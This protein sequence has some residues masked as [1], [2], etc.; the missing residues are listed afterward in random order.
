MDQQEFGLGISA[1]QLLFFKVRNL[2]LKKKINLSRSNIAE[3]IHKRFSRRR[4]KYA[5][6]SV[7]SP[8]K[9]HTRFESLVILYIFLINPQYSKHHY[10]KEA[11]FAALNHDI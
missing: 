2:K 6:F 5:R 9:S 10:Q 3:K 7:H 11:H 4:G 1:I 8:S